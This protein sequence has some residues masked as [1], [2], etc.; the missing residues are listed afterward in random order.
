[1]LAL[2][3]L[4]LVFACSLSALAHAQADACIGA[5]EAA[6]RAR[7]G[8]QFLEAH[9]HLVQCAQSICPRVVRNDCATWAN[10]VAASTPSLVLA[11]EGSRAEDL[12]AVRVL[13]NGTLITERLDGR[14]IEVDPGVYTLRFEAD[15]HAPREEKISVREGEKARL[16]RVRLE[17]PQPRVVARQPEP[18]R[19]WSPAVLTLGSVAVASGVAALGL[20]VRG[21][22][23]YQDVRASCGRARRCSESDVDAGQRAYIAADV[24]AGVAAVSAAAAVWWFVR[25][26]RE[27]ATTVHAQANRDGLLVSMQK[28]F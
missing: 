9:K 19:T 21:K 12:S 23:E 18:T 7:Q 6:Q 11:V 4:I 10:E 17:S 28:A 14:A 5:Y 25:D 24:L 1:M 20:G 27:R 15:G 26:R 22:R 2:R 3:A 16:V 13:A 8:G